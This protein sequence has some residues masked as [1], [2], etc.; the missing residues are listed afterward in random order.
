MFLRAPVEDDARSVPRSPDEGAD[1]TGMV[2]TAQRI[3]DTRQFPPTTYGG[4]AASRPAAA[5]QTRCPACGYPN[6]PARIRCEHCGYAMRPAQPQAV[7]LGPPPVPAPRRSSGWIWLIVLFVLA[8][9]AL[10]GA[11]LWNRLAAT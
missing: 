3:G 10:A 5:G 7:V 8:L 4:T 9:L 2:A 6:E 1:N 11:L